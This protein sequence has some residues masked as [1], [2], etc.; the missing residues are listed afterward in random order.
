METTKFT[1]KYIAL[2]LP[3]FKTSTSAT[4]I[5][6]ISHKTGEFNKLKLKPLSEKDKADGWR[7]VLPT[8]IKKYNNL[9]ISINLAQL[10]EHL[11]SNIKNKY[12]K[13]GSVCQYFVRDK[14]FKYYI[15]ISPVDSQIKELYKEI[16]STD[17]NYNKINYLLN[18]LK[19]NE[20]N[21]WLV[22]RASSI[23]EQ[24]ERNN[25]YF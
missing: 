6:K 14:C 23:L 22:L 21:G 16:N 2:K 18:I 3:I 4:G 20:I 17:Y 15:N 25:T 9:L 8:Y 11:W 5:T 24:N 12:N 10:P 1:K 7:L 19:E 13:D